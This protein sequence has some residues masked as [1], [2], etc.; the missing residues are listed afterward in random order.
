MLLKSI[1]VV[2]TLS[3]LLGLGYFLRAKNIIKKNDA[4]LLSFLAISVSV[5]A[6]IFVSTMTNFDKA[7]LIKFAPTVFLPITQTLLLFVISYFLCKIIKLPKN[8]FGVFAS[9]FSFG[10]IGLIGLP[11]AAS[12]LGIDSLVYSSVFFLSNTLIFWTLSVYLIKRDATIM[13]ESKNTQ[14]NKTS[15]SEKLKV[16]IPI[17]KTP[18][19]ITFLVTIILILLEIKT[20]EFLFNSVK[21]LSNIGTPFAMI[22]LGTIVC[23][24]K[25]MKFKFSIDLVLLSV[26]RFILAPLI[27]ILFLRFGNYS[28]ELKESFILYSG[29]AAMT[30]IGVVAGIHGADKEYA[31]Y[32][33]MS[34]IFLYPISLIL[35]QFLLKLI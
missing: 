1:N 32:A 13:L 29:I 30:Q 7:L 16:I 27:M 26:G 17:L 12:V 23:D 20:P 35:F 19:I 9:I 31:A 10:N 14:K 25:D 33:I 4:N 18:T 11:V 21:Y 6:N 3:S 22:Y 5:P 28:Y 34:T 15:F 2:L 8:R 24:A